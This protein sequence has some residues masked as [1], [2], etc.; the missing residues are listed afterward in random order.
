MVSQYGCYMNTVFVY[1]YY[2]ID[3]HVSLLVYWDNEVN[4]S[5]AL[6]MRWAKT[7][8]NSLSGR[9]AKCWWLISAGHISWHKSW[10]GHHT[11]NTSFS[12]CNS[13]LVFCSDPRIYR[14]APIGIGW[15]T[16]CIPPRYK[17]ENNVVIFYTYYAALCLLPAALFCPKSWSQTAIT[18]T[19]MPHS[20]RPWYV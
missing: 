9:I 18:Y 11:A 7:T 1:D 4:W 17:S 12:Y 19:V 8:Y 10:I 15:R 16:D 2:T 13:L 14:F 3:V 20:E 5:N 6:N